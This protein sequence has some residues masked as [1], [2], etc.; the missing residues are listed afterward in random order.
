MTR[1]P[2]FISKYKGEFFM[3][4]FSW[5]MLTISFFMIFLAN[6]TFARVV[7]GIGLGAHL[8]VL[9]IYYFPPAWVVTNLN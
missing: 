4:T 3:P 8:T 2:F 7:W 1:P 6:K 9:I 5:I